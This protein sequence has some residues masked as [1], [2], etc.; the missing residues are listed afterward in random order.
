MDEV[1]KCLIQKQTLFDKYIA[2][3]ENIQTIDDA[4][5][6]VIALRNSSVECSAALIDM[7]TLLG[8]CD[9]KYKV[10]RKNSFA[11]NLELLGGVLG[12]LSHYIGDIYENNNER[13]YRPI[14]FKT[15]KD[16]SRKLKSCIDNVRSAGTILLDENS[17]KSTTLLSDLIADVIEVQTDE[18]RLSM[19]LDNILIKLQQMASPP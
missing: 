16:S 18:R 14:F 4:C 17:I 9:D 12:S 5:S 6:S 8:N 15:M 1:M 2:L 19:K 3:F 13:I 7:K 10:K 11:D